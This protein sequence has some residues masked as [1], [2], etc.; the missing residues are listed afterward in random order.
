MW[1]WT[2]NWGE[3]RHDLLIGSAPITTPDLDRI[4]Q[5]TFATAVLSLQT[6]ECRTHFGIDYT[7]QMRYGERVGL[8]LVNTPMRDFDPTDQRRRLPMA[9]RALHRLL[10]KGYKVYVHCSAGINRS[11]LT[12][13]GYLTFIEG[14]AAN[15]AMELIH[16]GRREA[17][18]Y[19]DAYEGCWK[20]LCKRYE[21]DIDQRARKLC[22][23]NPGT[24]EEANWQQAR[25]EIVRESIYSCR[26]LRNR[27][28]IS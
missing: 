21:S 13:L 28:E 5:E 8:V 19:M 4:R 3:I 11:P 10:E 27:K 12:V 16:N 23:N 20:D 15:D 9:V 24:T 14:M 25:K 17:E 2:L 22:R 26:W 6:L 18:P 7:E 1:S